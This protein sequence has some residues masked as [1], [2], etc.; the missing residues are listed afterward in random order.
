M[1]ITEVYL[2]KVQNKLKD[3]TEE[4]VIKIQNKIFNTKKKYKKKRDTLKKDH[5]KEIEKVK[6]KSKETAI[7][8][9]DDYVS[10]LTDELKPEVEII[11][12]RYLTKLGQLAFKEKSE[13]LALS[14]ILNISKSG[15]YIATGLG[16]AG[17]IISG[18]YR[19]QQH[20]K[21]VA[22]E[23]CSNYTGKDIKVCFK[24]EKIKILKKRLDYINQQTINCKKSKHS[25]RCEVELH[26]Y[27]LKIKAQITDE[28]R[29]FANRKSV[30]RWNI[31]Q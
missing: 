30:G 15:A 21:E 25:R 10:E 19:I 6:E 12:K 23:K 5:Y 14:K 13:I 29:T 4:K 26:K 16:M 8:I 9:K 2:K 27:S 28:L 20:F 18:S 17:L 7:D 11:T 1:N 24:I 31:Y 3:N 22:K